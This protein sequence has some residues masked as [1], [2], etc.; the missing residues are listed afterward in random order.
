MARTSDRGRRIDREK[1]AVR[2]LLFEMEP[3]IQLLEGV[4]SLLCI[5]GES[6][7]SVEPVALATLANCC[8]DTVSEVSS[9]WRA[10]LD[11]LNNP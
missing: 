9:S 10:A 6:H 4:V 5:L 3:Q 8:G 1:A 7:D 2:D 11:G